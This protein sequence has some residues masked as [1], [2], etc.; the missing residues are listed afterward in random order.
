M[1][2]LQSN[3]KTRVGLIRVLT[4]DDIHMLNI[5]GA[6]IQAL[7]PDLEVVTRCIP[8]HEKGVY[9]DETSASAEPLVVGLAQEFV[10]QGCS[11]VVISCAGDP[12]LDL[13]RERV[14]STIIGAGEATALVAKG[15]GQRVGVIGIGADVPAKMKEILG[16]SLVSYVTPEGVATTNDLFDTKSQAALFEAGLKLKKK[17]AKVIA[18]ACTG[19]S[20]I[21]GASFLRRATGLKVIDPVVAAGVFA[22]HAMLF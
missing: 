17:G 8:D 12:G 7:F 3:K 18:L 11:V 6:M 5:H 10:K 9:D 4:T 14:G 20:T 1:G 21:G 19:L 2:F 16:S 13:A 15:F 22:H